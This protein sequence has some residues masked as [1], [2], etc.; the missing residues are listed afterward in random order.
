MGDVPD[1]LALRRPKVRRGRHPR[2]LERRLG[3]LDRLGFRLVERLQHLVEGALDDTAEIRAARRPGGRADGEGL[4]GR[5]SGE[6]VGVGQGRLVRLPA[7]QAIA[8]V[9]RLRG[10][11]CPGQLHG[12]DFLVG[13]L[14]RY[15]ALI[16]GGDQDPPELGDHVQ[17]GRVSFGDVPGARSRRSRTTLGW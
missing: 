2:D 8:R 16:L 5:M 17:V 6:R 11:L 4:H 10:C 13:R 1:N 12:A 14:V 9:S 7:E 3:E 15:F